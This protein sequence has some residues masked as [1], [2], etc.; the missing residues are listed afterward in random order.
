MLQLI[1]ISNLL[2]GIITL[3]F[4]QNYLVS[5]FILTLIVKII[6]ILHILALLTSIYLNIKQLLLFH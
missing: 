3:H 5:F 4:I 2:S 1:T 6:F